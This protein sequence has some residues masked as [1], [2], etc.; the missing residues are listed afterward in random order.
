MG[1]SSSTKK[2]TP[3]TCPDGYDAT[4]FAQITR[5]FDRLDRDGDF[6]VAKQELA[7]IARLHVENRVRLVK[8]KKVS[9]NKSF[10]TVL[11]NIDLEIQEKK[12][13]SRVAYEK[14][15]TRLDQEAARL[16]GLNSSG[17]CDEFM[18]AIKADDDTIDFW[19][20]F[21]YMK[22]RTSDIKNISF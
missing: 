22:T 12:Q 6:G 7:D 2:I 1:C 9:S 3:L 11:A 10:E 16:E 5:L 8:E 14:E 21:D 4:Q 13:S 17:Q 18:V 15:I 20:F 19:T